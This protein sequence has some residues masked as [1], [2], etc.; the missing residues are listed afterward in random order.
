M[1]YVYKIFLLFLCLA[2]ISAAREIHNQPGAISGSISPDD[3]HV[4]ILVKR[5]GTSYEKGDNL[6]GIL[7]LPHGG[8]FTF[9]EIPPGEYDMLFRLQGESRY[10]YV[11]NNWTRIIVQSGETTSGIDYRLT[12]Q[13]PI[14]LMKER[15]VVPEPTTL[16]DEI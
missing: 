7:T 8:A 5:A 2:N 3:V 14:S 13:A 12:P 1:K 4:T 6:K 9:S 16:I 10:K 11:V 15:P